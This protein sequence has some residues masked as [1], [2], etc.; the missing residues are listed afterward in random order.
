VAVDEQRHPHYGGRKRPAECA[1]CHRTV[2]CLE[3]DTPDDTGERVCPQCIA[4]AIDVSWSDRKTVRPT[5]NP[6]VMW[7]Y[8]DEGCS[9][10]E[11]SHISDG[12]WNCVYCGVRLYSR[13]RR[14]IG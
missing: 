3:V 12:R 13:K 7:A 11:G 6:T 4:V 14:Q 5:D 9:S 2:L 10:R 1:V 8:D